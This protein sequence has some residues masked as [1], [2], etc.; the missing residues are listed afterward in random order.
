MTLR[1][2]FL[3]VGMSLVCLI[4]KD[5]FANEGGVIR[6]DVSVVRSLYEDFASE[7]VLDDLETQRQLLDQPEAV[8]A[9]Y[10]TPELTSLIRHDREC[11]ARTKEI[12]RLD[13]MPIWASQDPSGATVRITDGA[14]LGEVVAEVR[15]PNGEK[16]KLI[17]Q[18]KK[19][20]QAGWMI[21]DIF[22]ADNGES[23]SKILSADR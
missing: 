5:S 1:G 23:L 4:V 19:K 8:L 6:A 11:A 20:V 9:R 22:Y 7:A 21:A 15:Y 14:T 10:F 18:L 2:L 12:C 3:L 16:K 13:F 17:Y